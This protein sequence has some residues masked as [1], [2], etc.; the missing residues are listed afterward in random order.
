MSKKVYVTWNEVSS[1]CHTIIRKMIKDNW[2][3]DV[4]VGVT[5][6]GVVPATMLSH[7]LG[8]PMVALGVSLRDDSLGIGSESNCWLPEM[9]DEGKKILIVDDINDTGATINWILNDWCYTQNYT[10]W[11]GRLRIATLHNNVVSDATV[12][13]DYPAV[14]IN[15]ME[16]DIWIVYP[17]ENFWETH[18]VN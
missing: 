11:D 7:Y 13:V 16:N 18:H 2:V 10:K 8:K 12:E 17:W 14:D 15:K 6:G 4:I 5:R 3:P 9:L 1:Y